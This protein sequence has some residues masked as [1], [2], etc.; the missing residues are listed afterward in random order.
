MIRSVYDSKEEKIAQNPHRTSNSKVI[1]LAL[2]GNPNVGKS[3]LFNV[4]TGETAHVANWPGVTV[5]V[6][7]GRL[8]HHKK[9]IVV[10]DLPGTYSLS[11]EAPDA[12]EA[13]AREFVAKH[14]PEVLVILVDA[15]ALERTMYLPI[16]AL[17][18]TP[19]VIIAVN[20]M[21]VAEKR[22]IH[23]DIDALSRELG[24]P[25]VGISALKEKG[26]GVLLDRVLDVAEGRECRKKPLKVDYGPLEPYIA[27]LEDL[28]RERGLLKDYPPRWVAVRLLEGDPVLL[29]RIKREEPKTASIIKETIESAKTSL[30]TDLALMAVQA[31]FSFIDSLLKGKVTKTRLISP[32]IEEKLDKIALHPIIGPLFASFVLLV[33]FL[34]V[35]AVNVG[36]PLNI[37]LSFL[38]MQNLAEL[39]ERY[40]L[41]NILVGIFDRFA[42]IVGTSLRNYPSWFASLVVDGAISGVASV[43]GFLPLILM[44]YL[45]LGALQD[46]GLMARVAVSLDRFFRRFGLSGKA[47]FPAVVGFG[48]SVPAVMSTRAMDDD[49]E[50]L[51]TAMTVPLIPCQAR[52]VVMLAVASV[53][54]S[55]PLGQAS[56]LLGIY[57]LS[58]GLY[59]LSSALLN[60]VIFKV[61]V[62][63]ELVL[64]VP[65]YHK[66]SLKV[67]WWYARMNAMKFIKRAGTII[68]GLSILLWFLLHFGPRG[69]ISMEMLETDAIAIEGT[70]AAVL[71][72]SLVPLGRLM[73]LG[74]WRIMLALETG[75]V[76]KE[77][78]LSTIVA[79]TGASSVNQAIEALGMTNLQAV[80][81]TIAMTTYVPCIATVGV[82]KQEL[83]LLKYLLM[84][85][86]Y[87]LLLAFTLAASTFWIGKI[88][89]FS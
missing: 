44:V 54:F 41:S 37:I 28:I 40:S 22:A 80:S 17:E 79:A 6:K 63:P 74:D 19:R 72:K 8:T 86:T 3:T 5:A 7:E 33:S 61:K 83:R 30:R 35:F 39:V 14:K 60:R 59:L 62:P 34:T 56:F 76:A 48:C 23:I 9:E 43:L 73:G 46:S 64:E 11:A 36:F 70:L 27:R 21:D 49:R 31:R 82:L 24:I 84:I 67:I 52:L 42:E 66:P 51:V 78:V 55:S 89:G 29:G 68:F 75:L 53:M 77:S 58:I 32:G 2:A 57:L 16:M 25:I 18:M 4:L 50:R 10:V 45:V 47:V 69:F 20:M 87:Q 81:L 15:T 88:I 26:I 65:P 38:G 71:G 12:A 1:I 13:I 85:I